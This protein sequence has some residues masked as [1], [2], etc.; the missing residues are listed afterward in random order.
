M[1]LPTAPVLMLGV[2]DLSSPVGT[3]SLDASAEAPKDTL[4]L[5]SYHESDDE[6][7]NAEFF[8]RHGLHDSADFIII[9]NGE[10]TAPNRLRVPEA[11]N[12]K[13]VRREDTCYHIGSYGEVLRGLGDV[14]K[15]YKRF[16]L[17]DA[18]I[19]GPFMPHWSKKCWSDAYLG[20]LNDQVKL[21][22]MSYNCAPF[23]RHVQSRILATDNIGLNLLLHPVSNSLSSCPSDWSSALAAEVHLTEE[24]EKAG[25]RTDVMMQGS[26]ATAEFAD[27]CKRRDRLWEGAKLSDQRDGSMNFGHPY[28]TIFFKAN[29]G[30]QEKLLEQLTN[31]TEAVEYNSY[32]VC[33]NPRW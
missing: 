28:E 26:R 31:R 24:I 3:T 2:R 27:R 1:L 10:E 33:R 4:I 20:R 12:I 18:T 14:I 23:D 6:R 19:R 7:R 25:Y 22:G 30:V 9:F 8:I 17:L 16:I 29:R 21:V 11:E 13:V 5:Y 15:Q 32:A